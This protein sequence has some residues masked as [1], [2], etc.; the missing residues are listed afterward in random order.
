MGI[1]SI[2]WRAWDNSARV[3][4][5]RYLPITI[6]PQPVVLGLGGSLFMKKEGKRRGK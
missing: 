6:W 4:E 3:G 1:L 2:N 5:R